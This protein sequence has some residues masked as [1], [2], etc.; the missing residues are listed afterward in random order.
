LRFQNWVRGHG[1]GSIWFSRIAR[2]EEVCFLFFQCG[3][4]GG[5]SAASAWGRFGFI[6]VPSASRGYTV[7]R[8]ANPLHRAG[9]NAK[10]LGNPTYTFTSALTL[11]QGGEDSLL[12]LGRYPGPAKSF[13]LVLGSPKP[14]ADSFCDHRALKLGKNAHHLKHGLAARQAAQMA[15]R[16]LPPPKAPTRFWWWPMRRAA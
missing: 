4:R 12:K 1:V 7:E 3:L 9:I 13:A 5:A 10:T 8:A 6:C 14:G 15:L 11:I 16:Q 2:R